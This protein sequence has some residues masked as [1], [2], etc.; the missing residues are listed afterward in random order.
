MTRRGRENAPAIGHDN[1]I[2]F[3]LTS[4]LLCPAVNH[5]SK[6]KKKIDTEQ[7]LLYPLAV[8]A[9]VYGEIFSFCF[10]I[11]FIRTEKPLNSLSFPG[12]GRNLS[13]E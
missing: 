2:T 5:I 4:H 13:G 12:V 8:S 9:S 11:L 6:T 7:L 10:V 3:W 1:V